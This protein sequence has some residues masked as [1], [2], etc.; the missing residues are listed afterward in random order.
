ML[1]ENN[2]TDLKLIDRFI[3]NISLD[4]SNN[5]IASYK[6]DLELFHK[7]LLL[8][9]VSPLN[10]THSEIAEYFAEYF[11]TDK[12][13]FVKII[14][15][16]SIRRKISVLRAFF[17]F[18]YEEKYIDQKPI[19]DVEIPKA[20]H[21]LPFYLTEEEVSAIFE[22]TNSKNTKDG[23]RINA[24][25]HILYSCGLRVSEAITMKIADVFDGQA[26]RKKTIIL[27][28]GNKERTI[29]IDKNA[30]KAINKY[31]V[32][33]DYFKPKSTN[34]FLFCAG[35][36]SEHLTRQAVF[37]ALQKIAYSLV[38]SEKTSPHKLRHSFATHMYQNGID[39]RMLQVLL[40]HSDIST[41]EIYTHIK[42]ADIKT[43]MEKFHPIFIKK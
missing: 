8:K 11:I 17:G 9:K 27:G 6:N 2:I 23:I 42:A 36:S 7:F 43:T 13:G 19:D 29:F 25:L 4:K 26:V 24:I 37:M 20:S 28:K 22:H 3:S 40:G 14:E 34:K 38:M 16:V 33:R 15:A 35:N 32:V 21:N 18:L 41:T 5:T 10:C 31:I 39:L 12:Y 1:A 30:Q